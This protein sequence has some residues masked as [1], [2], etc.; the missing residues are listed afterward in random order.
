MTVVHARSN[1]NI[2]HDRRSGGCHATCTKKPV[3]LLVA[4]PKRSSSSRRVGIAKRSRCCSRT[5]NAFS[6]RTAQATRSKW[7]PVRVHTRGDRSEPATA[8]QNDR[9]PTATDRQV[10]CMSCVR[11]LG[12]LPPL[13]ASQSPRR[14]NSQPV[15]TYLVCRSLL[16]QYRPIADASRGRVSGSLEVLIRHAAS[17]GVQPNCCSGNVL[18]NESHRGSD[19][20]ACK[21]GTSPRA[22]VPQGAHHQRPICQELARRASQIGSQ[23]IPGYENIRELMSDMGC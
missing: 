9:S 17:A 10:C 5:S 23:G 16:Q 8:R 14:Y 20:P 13:A 4:S 11:H 1:P 21:Q 2:V 3:T 19:I 18:H 6:A 7:C 22:G 12:F 15:A